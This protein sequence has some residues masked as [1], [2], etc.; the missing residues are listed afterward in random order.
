MKNGP[1]C[2]PFWQV[3]QRARRKARGD[4][5]SMAFS[6]RRV[7]TQF[8]V[9]EIGLLS[10]ISMT[11]PVWYSPFSSWAWYL[12]DFITILPY[13]A[14]FTRRSTSTVTVLA[15]LSLTT[16]PI[17]V[18]LREVLAS[19]MFTPYLVLV[20]VARFWARMVLARA[21]SRRV[22]RSVPV[23][24][25]CCVAFCM[26]RPKWAFCRDFTSASTP[27]TSFWRRSLALVISSPPSGAQHAGHERRA[28]RQLGG[29]QLER[30]AR[31]FLGHADDLE[32]DLARLDFGHVVLGV[33]L[34]VTHTHF[35]GLLG[36]RL[37]REHADPDAAAT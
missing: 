34:A 20:S 14:C 4:Q 36:D 7:T 26:R 9:L 30:F 6:T 11:S 3:L 15:R 28:Q 35:S 19:V 32:H 37:V 23:L 33:A 8:L 1:H 16:L 29:S 31:E 25:S 24:V 22:L 17:R 18:R 27:A 2:G 13:S 10:S 21:M 5:T 12:L